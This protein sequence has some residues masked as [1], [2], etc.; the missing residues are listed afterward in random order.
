MP[1][2]A[3]GA[4]RDFTA[5]LLGAKGVGGMDFAGAEAEIDFVRCGA[6]GVF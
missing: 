5:N 4:E 1:E 2:I 6:D 3:S